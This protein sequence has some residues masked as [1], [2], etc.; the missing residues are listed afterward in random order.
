MSGPSLAWKNATELLVIHNHPQFKVASVDLIHIQSLSWCL[1]VGQEGSL[2]IMSL[3][4]GWYEARI[5]WTWCELWG[6][7]CKDMAQ[8]PRI[9][10]NTSMSS[11]FKLQSLQSEEHQ[12]ITFLDWFEMLDRVNRRQFQ[13]AR[14]LFVVWPFI[15]QIYL[16]IPTYYDTTTWYHQVGIS[17]DQLKLFKLFRKKFWKQNLLYRLVS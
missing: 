13:V 11:S 10:N 2:M 6:G 8:K 17:M 1:T 7:C 3:W 16:S 9:L 4:W 12:W 15:S 14:S 5:T